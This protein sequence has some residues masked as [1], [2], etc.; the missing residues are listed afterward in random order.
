MINLRK[1][2]LKT[3]LMIVFETILIVLVVS[4]YFFLRDIVVGIFFTL[5]I[6]SV[7][8]WMLLLVITVNFNN[9]IHKK[10][11]EKGNE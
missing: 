1:Y 2:L 3:K 10:V 6:V 11:R 4:S 7:H 9:K 5:F 8:I